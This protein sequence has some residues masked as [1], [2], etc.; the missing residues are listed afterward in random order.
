MSGERTLAPAPPEF[1]FEAL[2]DEFSRKCPW[3]CERL[4]PLINTKVGL[5][6]VCTNTREH[7]Q[8]KVFWQ[9]EDG[10]EEG[11]RN[12]SWI[13]DAL[14]TERGLPRREQWTS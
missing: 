6:L 3:C 12:V 13:I 14:I 11:H 9:M 2:E 7:G 8:T 4:H 1:D 10:L 5:V